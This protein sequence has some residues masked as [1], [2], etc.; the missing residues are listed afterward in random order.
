MIDPAADISSGESDLEPMA[1]DLSA[2]GVP[3]DRAAIHDALEV[4]EPMVTALQAMRDGNHRAAAQDIRYLAS[5][6]RTE[7]QESLF[8]MAAGVLLRGAGRS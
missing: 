2:G 8:R 6:D 7:E 1:R 3:V 4:L 5:L